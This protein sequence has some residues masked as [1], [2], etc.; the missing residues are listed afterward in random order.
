MLCREAMQVMAQTKMKLTL[1]V[2]EAHLPSGLLQ[3]NC[4]IVAHGS[5]LRDVVHAISDTVREACA[6]LDYD[7]AVQHC[8]LRRM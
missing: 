4:E 7:T 2:T 6:H 8:H 1:K 3:L 5:R